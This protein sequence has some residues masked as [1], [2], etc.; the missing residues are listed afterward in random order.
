LGIFESQK[1]VSLGLLLFEKKKK[2]LLKRKKKGENQRAFI[3]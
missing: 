3:S 1:R 2:T